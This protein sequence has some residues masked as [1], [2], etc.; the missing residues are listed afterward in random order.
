MITW[1]AKTVRITAN[2]IIPEG[3]VYTAD[4]RTFYRAEANNEMR[5][6]VRD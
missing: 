5:E 3:D 1:S 2:I 4:G 6:G